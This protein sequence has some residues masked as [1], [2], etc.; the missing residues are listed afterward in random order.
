MYRTINGLPTTRDALYGTRIF[1]CG[2]C[3]VRWLPSSA[4]RADFRDT[5]RHD[6]PDNRKEEFAKEMESLHEVLI[7]GISEAQDKQAQ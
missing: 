7:E 5:A 4:T 1:Y 6:E 2:F 3:G